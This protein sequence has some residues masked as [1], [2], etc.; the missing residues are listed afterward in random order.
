MAKTVLD[1]LRSLQSLL[2]R[3]RAWNRDEDSVL[4]QFLYGQAEEFARVDSRSDD[5]QEERDIRYASEL[6]ID[7]EIDLGLPDECSAEAQTIQERRFAAHAKLIAL[8]QQNPAYFIQLAAALGWTITITEY[9][10]FW[11]GYGVSG[12]P[13]GCQNNIFYWKASIYVY[14]LEII[15]FLCGSSEC[16]DLLSYLPDTDSLVCMLNKYKPAHT[17]FLYDYDGPEFTAAF[18]DSFDASPY[19]I[20]S[21]LTGGFSLGFA[22][23]F[24][25]G[26]GAGFD[27]N[28]FD[29]GF[30]KSFYNPDF[31]YTTGG[32][33][34]GFSLGFGD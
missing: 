28:G 2:P 18:S 20:S 7:H 27:S 14:G 33:S 24:E 16:G 17:I 15:Y 8:G 34:S 9:K 3:G 19:A 5:L 12:E 31:D 26:T 11:C 1:Y 4:F 22:I 23:G 30:E 10:P 25:I 29:N 32:F 21:Y 6:L 13:C